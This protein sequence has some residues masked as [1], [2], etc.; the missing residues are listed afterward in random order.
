[1]DALFS[2]REPIWMRWPP[3]AQSYGCTGSAP[4]SAPVWVRCPLTADPYGCGGFPQRPHISTLALPSNPYRSPTC[5]CWR[6]P[7][8]PYGFP[9]GRQ[10]GGGPGPTES[11]LVSLDCTWSHLVSLGFAWLHWVALVLTWS[12]LVSPP[13]AARRCSPQDVKPRS[14]QDVKPR[15]PQDVKPCSPQDVKPRSPQDVKPCSPQ[16]VEGEL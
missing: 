12:R 15:S 7:V 1:M 10:R 5:V 16:D 3:P 6:E 13:A 4:S 8:H 11:H 9:G 14:P 2:S